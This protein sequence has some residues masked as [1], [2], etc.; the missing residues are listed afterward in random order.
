MSLPTAANARK[1]QL[2]PGT[3]F[4]R[5]DLL[6]PDGSTYF[7]CV[8]NT[9]AITINGNDYAPCPVKMSDVE[10]VSGG[11]EVPNP[12]VQLASL[13][14]VEIINNYVRPF[15]GL[16]GSVLTMTRVVAEEPALDMS[17]TA[18]RYD[19]LNY[20]RGEKWFTLYLGAARLQSQP[21]PWTKYDPHQRPF[22]HTSGFKGPEC[23]Y[24]GAETTC[25]GSYEDCRTRNNRTEYGGE[26]GLNDAATKY[27]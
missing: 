17:N 21:I 2:E 3:W 22:P 26:I 27:A 9:Q 5:F 11:G 25:S 18:Q 10:D 8:D 16:R 20:S 6:L 24:A 1:N 19:V 4:W 23:K 12:T 13:E 7:R 14:V 15:V